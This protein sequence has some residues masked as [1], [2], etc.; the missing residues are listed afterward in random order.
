MYFVIEAVVIKC[1]RGGHKTS[2]LTSKE[3]CYNAPQSCLV[4]SIVH[5]FLMNRHGQIESPILMFF[6]WPG[7]IHILFQTILRCIK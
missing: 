1:F 3:C 6:D 4:R 2:H 7:Y 5:L